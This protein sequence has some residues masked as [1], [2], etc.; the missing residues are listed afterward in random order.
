VEE[1]FEAS[2]DVDAGRVIAIEY[3]GANL[4]SG[5]L[6]IKSATIVIRIAG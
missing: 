4:S 3:N 1:Q 2:T 5:Q 6:I